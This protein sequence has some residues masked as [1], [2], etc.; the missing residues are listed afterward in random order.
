MTY[1]R[2]WIHPRC[3]AGP[4]LGALAAYLQICGYDMDKIM[5]GPEDRRGFCEL[6]RFIAPFDNG[7]IMYERMDGTRFRHKEGTPAPAGIDP[8]QPEAA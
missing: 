1:A 8:I 4:A 5:I 2:I 3:V 6:V 7:D